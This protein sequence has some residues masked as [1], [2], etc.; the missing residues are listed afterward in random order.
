[1]SGVTDLV[2]YL[3]AKYPTKVTVLGERSEHAIRGVEAALGI[4]FPEDYRE[5]LQRFGQLGMGSIEIYGLFDDRSV[6][7]GARM[8]VEER[9]YGLPAHLFV[10]Y[11]HDGDQLD[12]LDCSQEDF[13]VVA[14]DTTDKQITGR[15]APSFLQYLEARAARFEGL[16]G[17]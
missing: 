12:C 3:L 4:K 1:M 15:L 16:E 7:D 9:V 11:S 8:T 5:F 2:Q 10:L 14:W 17:A 6:Q 13:P